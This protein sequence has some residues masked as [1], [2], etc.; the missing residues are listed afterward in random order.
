MMEIDNS[1]AGITVA[2]GSGYRAVIPDPLPPTPGIVVKN[3]IINLLSQADIAP[4]RGHD[5]PVATRP[6]LR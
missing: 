2:Q 1:R 5:A 4:S 3:E 6:I